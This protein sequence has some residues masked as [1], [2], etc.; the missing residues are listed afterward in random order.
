MHL[1][2]HRLAA[3]L[4][5][6]IGENI[7]NERAPLLES[8]RGTAYLPFRMSMSDSHD[9]G[10][11]AYTDEHLYVHLMI[12][13]RAW[14][15]TLDAR[16]PV[17][18]DHN[19]LRFTDSRDQDT[20]VRHS[21]TRRYAFTDVLEPRIEEHLDAIAKRMHTPDRVYLWNLFPLERFRGTSYAT[22]P[23]AVLD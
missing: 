22:F 10:T 8:M 17:E 3:N 6:S 1:P 7:W 20:S 15:C 2:S 11:D 23:L 18:C 16:S 14:Y 12:E 5:A 4:I 21:S 13:Q 9:H 19:L